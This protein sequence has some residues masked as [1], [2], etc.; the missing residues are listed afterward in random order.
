MAGDRRWFFGGGV[1]AVCCLLSGCGNDKIATVEGTI[2]LDGKPLEGAVVEFYPTH[3]GGASYGRTDAEGHYELQYNR[4]EAGAE[5][6]RHKVQITTFADGG[7]YGQG[8]KELLPT[9]YNSETEL[10]VEV[11][12]GHNVIDFLELTSEGKIEENPRNY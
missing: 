11:K 9:R 4:N 1:A 8:R 6:G 12:R 10:E 3:S 2:Y 7:G 5:I